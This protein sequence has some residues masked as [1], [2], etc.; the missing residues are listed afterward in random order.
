M[1]KQNGTFWLLD[2]LQSITTTDDPTAWL[3]RIV[4]DYHRP[5]ARFTPKSRTALSPPELN[6][7]SLLHYSNVVSNINSDNFRLSLLN[8]L[9]LSYED[10]RSRSHSF[11][12][13][14]A[15]RLRLMQ[16]EDVFTKLRQQSDVLADLKQWDFSPFHPV[17]LI[18]GLLV[19]TDVHYDTKHDKKQGIGG[20]VDPVS[21][22]SLAAGV[23]IPFDSSVGQHHL[24]EQ[25][26][27]MEGTVQGTRIFAI[28]YRVIK[29]RLFSTHAHLEPHG[30]RGDR[31][32]GAD[33]HEER[34]RVGEDVVEKAMLEEEGAFAE[35]VE[36]EEDDEREVGRC[37]SIDLYESEDGK[38]E[39]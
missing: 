25:S 6:E 17:Y 11:R 38:E 5:L 8:L 10:Y 12:T 15:Q 9:G 22:G 26:D 13:K 28:E 3:G 20:H 16:D 34:G 31:A 1:G 29:K 14:K 36:A 35:F 21:V 30:P 39:V 19:A 37:F 32:F 23:P 2:P 24:R 18:V 4:Y 33:K 27:H 7:T